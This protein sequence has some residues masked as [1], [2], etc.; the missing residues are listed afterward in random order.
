MFGVADGVGR[1][2]YTVVG[3]SGGGSVL[4]GGSGSNM[5]LPVA[6]VIMNPRESRLKTR[7]MAASP[8]SGLSLDAVSTYKYTIC[9]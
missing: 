8:R 1:A 3:A 5:I 2:R 9:M 4:I 6:S 7:L